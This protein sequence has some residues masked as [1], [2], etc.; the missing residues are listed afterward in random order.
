MPDGIDRGCKK[1]GGVNHA[2]N[3]WLHLQAEASNVAAPGSNCIY[4][5]NETAVKLMI[6]HSFTYSTIPYM[7]LIK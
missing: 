1:I 2:I 3:S 5:E 7:Y 4:M 6:I